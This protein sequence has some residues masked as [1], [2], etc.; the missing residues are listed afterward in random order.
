[1][2][3]LV[4][5]L[6]VFTFGQVRAWLRVA[7][8]DKNIST[9]VPS[10]FYFPLWTKT[11]GRSAQ[12]ECEKWS[13]LRIHWGFSAVLKTSTNSV[14]SKAFWCVKVYTLWKFIQNTINW[15][16]K[17]KQMWKKSIGKVNVTTNALLSF[18]SF[19]SSIFYF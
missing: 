13:F 9:C 8:N 14:R 10:C 19:N 2:A 11:T 3:I 17:L 12:N 4:S 5:F 6:T 18:T 7:R 1:M 15:V 16:K